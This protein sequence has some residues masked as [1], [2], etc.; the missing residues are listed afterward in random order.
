VTVAGMVLRGVAQDGGVRAFMGIPYATPPVGDKRWRVS[1][2]AHP[3]PG[4]RDATR[5]GAVCP[6]DGAIA[7]FTRRLASALNTEAGT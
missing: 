5:P 1:T 2:L 3:D 6:Q 7:A 4:P